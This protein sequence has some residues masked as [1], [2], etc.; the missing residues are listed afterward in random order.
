MVNKLRRGVKRM[1]RNNGRSPFGS[2]NLPKLVQLPKSLQA[3]RNTDTMAAARN[4]V[5]KAA[6]FKGVVMGLSKTGARR[7]ASTHVP[8]NFPEQAGCLSYEGRG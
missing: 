7:A 8:L 4:V 3:D 1:L 2:K 5:N 6:G